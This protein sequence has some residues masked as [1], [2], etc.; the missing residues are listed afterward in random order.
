ME[1]TA[2]HYHV[3]HNLPGYLPDGDPTTCATFADAL[4]SLIDDLTLIA[5]DD[6]MTCGDHAHLV[7]YSSHDNGRC[8]TYGRCAWNDA[9]DIRRDIETLQAHDSEENIYV[10]LADDYVYW[11]E[12]CFEPDC[13]YLLDD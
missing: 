2:V 7:P 9:E 12:S 11:I 5:D 1:T 8:I 13:L 10:N 4:T 3:G 6:E